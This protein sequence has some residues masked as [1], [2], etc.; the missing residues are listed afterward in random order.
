MACFILSKI[1]FICVILKHYV[2][3]IVI[4]YRTNFMQYFLNTHHAFL[5]NLDNFSEHASGTYIAITGE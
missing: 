5:A 3:L 1:T 2:L 4:A